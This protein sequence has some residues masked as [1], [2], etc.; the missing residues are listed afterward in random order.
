MAKGVVP[1]S[2]KRNIS[3]ARSTALKEADVVLVLGAKLNWILSFG[4]PPKWRPDVKI[5]QVD[6]DANELGKNSADPALSLLGDLPLV[7][8]QLV[9][10]FGDWKWQGQSSA[11]Y[12]TLQNAKA[13]NEQ[14]A[15]AKAKVEKLPMTYERSFDVIRNTLNSLSNPADGDIV[16]VSEGANAMDISRSIFTMEHPRI[17]LDAGTHATMGVGLGYAIAAYAAYNVTHPEGVAGPPGRKKIV[18]IEGDSA[19][20]FSGMEVETMARY[21]M[22]IL[23]FVINN[24]GLY[25][26]D[27]DTE[28]GWQE[29]QQVSIAGKTGESQGLTATSLGYETPYHKI[30]DMSGNGAI[31]ILARTPAELK[32]ATEIGFK[33]KVPVVV[34]VLIDP[35]ADL[36]MVSLPMLVT[37]RIY[38]NV[39]QD[40]SWLD[41]APP[42]KGKEAKL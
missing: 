10:E 31:G 30:A 6:L 36:V 37:N 41:M 16:Y 9:A 34:N 27:A 35:Q 22:D 24:G 1:D 7:L 21:E 42:K 3:A 14:K 18:A 38:A 23:I 13:R 20:G 15:A 5:I 28:Q 40:F 12:R 2:D 32:E 33:A 11:F 25:R 4:L 19:F 39:K 29:R 26:G 17:R 8:E